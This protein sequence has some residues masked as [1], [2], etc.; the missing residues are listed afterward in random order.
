MLPFLALGLGLMAGNEFLRQKKITDKENET[1]QAY[2]GLLG[3]AGGNIMGPPTEGGQMGYTG[4][5]GLLADPSNIQKQLQFAAGVAGL[6]GQQAI[7]LNMLNAAFQ[8]QQAQSQA[9]QGQANWQAQW[10]RQGTRDQLADTRWNQEWDAQQA[11]RAAQAEQQ[12]QAQ[13]NWEAQFGLSQQ[14]FAQQ[15]KQ[16]QASHALAQQAANRAD[17]AAKA[18]A[19][20]DLPK[21]PVG[22][23]WAPDGRGGFAPQPL[24]NTPDWQKA[25]GGL[26]AI[27]GAETRLKD[28]LDLI[29]GKMDTGAG[30][31]VGGAGTELYGDT[32]TKMTALRG[33]IR[34]DI[35]KARELGALM[36]FEQEDLDRQMPDPTTFGA[37]F[38]GN[39]NTM[40]GYEELLRQVQ[41]KKAEFYRVNPWMRPPPPERGK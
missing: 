15:G 2:K 24:P 23:A 11:Q 19:E 12:A 35:G 21:I 3:S 27:T 28:M 31:R 10:D 4:G 26:E 33:A 9:D 41:Q 36:G 22:Y 6:P 39:K 20:P 40:A 32:A 18:K 1:A 16:W 38:K 30:V 34:S 17:A 25:K 8:R 5:S 14:Q 13:R 37:A 7:G 29:G